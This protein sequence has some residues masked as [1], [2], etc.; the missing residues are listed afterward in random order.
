MVYCS[1]VFIYWKDIILFNI[2]IVFYFEVSLDVIWF[3]W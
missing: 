2:S 3:I 1:I